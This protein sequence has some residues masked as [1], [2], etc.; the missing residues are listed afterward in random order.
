MSNAL[1]IPAGPDLYIREVDIKDLKEQDLNA[2]VMAPATFERLVANIKQR[3][4]PES[5]PYC[6]QPGGKGDTEIVSGHHRV[7]ASRA[8]GLERIHV[9]VDCSEMTRSQIVAKQMAHNHLVGSDDPEVAK[10]LIEQIATPDDRLLSGLPDEVFGQTEDVDVMRLFT[11]RVD[12]DFRT[13]TF[14]FLPHQQGELE[15]LID[16]LEGRRDLVVA[17][18][19]EQFDDL[20][21]TA[22]KYARIKKVKSGGTAITLMIR[23]AQAEIDAHEAEEANATGKGVVNDGSEAPVRASKA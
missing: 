13:V 16:M 1:G 23:L 19:I 15:R 10:Q 12:F 3:G 11:P 20:L 5:M 18:P 4:A 8:A 6:A 22:A 9:L 2:N 21:K 7:R 14:A 17:A